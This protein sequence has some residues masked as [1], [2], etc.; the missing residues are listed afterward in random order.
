MST[1]EI[2][3]ES[4]RNAVKQA[5]VEV[6]FQLINEILKS[7]TKTVTDVLRVIGNMADKVVEDE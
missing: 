1:N 3:V 2:A 6:M 4:V 7:E 5:K